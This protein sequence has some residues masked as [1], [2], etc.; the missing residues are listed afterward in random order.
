L[1][2]DDSRAG[3]YFVAAQ[4]P[5]GSLY[6]NNGQ[7]WVSFTGGAIP[8]RMTETLTQRSFPVFVGLDTRGLSG[9]QILVGYGTDAN[10][11]LNNGKYRAIYTIP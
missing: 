7:G 2:L 8:S 5:D 4:L 6:L 10:D 11:M 9:T 1:R 3:A